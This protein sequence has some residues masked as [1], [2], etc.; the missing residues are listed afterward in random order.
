MRLRTI[1]KDGALAAL[2][3]AKPGV[4][5]AKRDVELEAARAEAA[6]LGEAPRGVGRPAAAGGGKPALGL[7]GRVPPRVD[8]ATKAGLL[9][10]LEQALKRGWTVRA[11]CQVL[12]VSELRI[13][14]WLGRRAAG[15]LEDQAPG[16][17]PMHGLLDWEVAAIVGL[18]EEWGEVDRSHHKLAHRGSRLG[19]VWVS[20]ASV[21]RVLAAHDLVLPTPPT[22]A[23]VG[24][25][26]WPDWITYRPNQV[27]GWDVTHFGRGR[28][29]PA[30]S[31]SSTWSAA[32]GWPPCS[33]PRRPPPRSRWCSV[34]RW[35]PR[36]CWSWWPPART[37][38][39]TWRW[40]T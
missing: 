2:A 26:P 33:A 18:A 27:W 4:A 29:A 34:T 25:T 9:G 11:V 15:E 12:E 6:R 23:P 10:L 16:G 20:P 36:A 1:A 19:R 3:D 30:R 37:A 28:A 14:R 32:S 17:S 7:S 8:A 40:M 38:E 5:A 21:Y 13:Y 35:G 22:R 31:R 24:R 39:W